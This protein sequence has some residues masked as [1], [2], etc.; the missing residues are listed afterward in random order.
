[1]KVL[2]ALSHE[3][4]DSSISMEIAQLFKRRIF[5]TL[6]LQTSG[7]FKQTPCATRLIISHFNNGTGELCVSPAST[8]AVA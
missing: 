4:L 2:S 7:S 5:F 3:R 8:L 6:I 1:M